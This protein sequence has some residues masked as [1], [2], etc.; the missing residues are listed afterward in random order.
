MTLPASWRRMRDN[1]N[2]RLPVRE[3]PF[4]PHFVHSR[5]TMHFRQI[6]FAFPGTH[7]TKVQYLEYVAT[8]R[9]R[10]ALPYFVEHYAKSVF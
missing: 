8:P 2:C 1:S 6:G 3:R 5:I 4:D 7:W 10:T 9:L